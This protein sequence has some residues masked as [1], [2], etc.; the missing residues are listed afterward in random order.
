MI[1]ST[2]GVG[3]DLLFSVEAE[4]PEEARRK[5]AEKLREFISQN[6][7]ADIEADADHIMAVVDA[8]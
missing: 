3:V 7:A 2:Y 5:G 8:D 4:S 1:G 6:D